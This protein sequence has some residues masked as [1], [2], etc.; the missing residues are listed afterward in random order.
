VVRLRFGRRL[1]DPRE[2]LL[3]LTYLVVEIGKRTGRVR[4]LEL[5]RGGA[6]LQL[7]RVQQCGK[8]RRDVVE[9]LLTPVFLFALE[10]LPAPFHLA[11]RA[12]LFRRFKDVRVPRD[13]LVVNRAGHARQIALALFLEQ[14]REEEGLEEKVA[15]LVLELAG[16]AADRRIGDLIGFL[17]GVRNDRPNRLLAVPGT[18]TAEPLG[19]TLK[20]E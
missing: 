17:D 10:I 16:V 19:Q 3:Q 12:Q 11:R 8:R 2:R 7:A 1:A 15:E 5:D 9:N 6:A 13:Q 20:I 14:Q 18:I 4:V